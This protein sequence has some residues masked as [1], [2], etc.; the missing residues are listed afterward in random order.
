MGFH[1]PSALSKPV[2]LLLSLLLV[3]A[4]TR[5]DAARDAWLAGLKEIPGRHVVLRAPAD[6]AKDSEIRDL[7][8]RLDVAAERMARKVPVEIDE[9]LQVFLEEDYVRQGR[10]VGEI[11]EAVLDE[12]GAVHLVFHRQD[13]P[14]YRQTVA[15]ALVRRLR[16]DL[17]PWI[18]RGAAL[19]L[20]ADWYGKPY[21]DWLPLFAAA[22]V[23]PT[24][25]QLLSREVQPDSSDLLWV[26]AA[27]H[28][29]GSRPGETLTDR[30]ATLPSRDEIASRL[31]AVRP[32]AADPGPARRAPARPF[33]HGVSFAMSNGLEIGYHAPSAI[34]RLNRL[35]GLGADAVSLMPFAYQ[36][37]P[38]APELRYLRRSPSSE[39][40]VGML[41]A[42]RQAHQRGMT[43]LW[44]PQI[45]LSHGS[46]P[47]EIR[48]TSEDDWEVW[49]AS[50]RRFILHHAVLARW[51]EVE[52]FSVGVELGETLDRQREWHQ[53]IRGARLL[54][55]GTLTYAANWH[56]DAEHAPFWPRLDAIGVDAYY[57]LAG[58]AEA[59]GETLREGARA[60]RGRLA[61]LAREHDRPIL[62]TEV[63]F[64]ARRSAW[65]SPH[66]EGGEFHPEDQ[67]RAYEVL[68]GELGKPPWLAGVFVWKAFSG[69]RGRPD[70]RPDFRFLDRPAAEIVETY[71]ER[72]LKARSP[73]TA[74]RP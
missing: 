34:E 64:A 56:G 48:M 11:G 51:A 54:F 14:A 35:A 28:V 69:D 33:L 19:W 21:E 45:W 40:D 3:P 73:A 8:R 31:A 74:G 13:E 68:F 10:Y 15:L 41:H 44:K 43:V 29:V 67:R 1:S 42:A 23:L 59:D 37:A 25:E 60:V 22:G 27:A 71:F 65:A 30:L 36:P 12:A 63:G 52:W 46:W 72:P 47:G 38:D 6:R 57:P 70:D 16:D 62:L 2:L 58:S 50:Y 61:A 17:P 5:A 39:T 26:P 20:S 55:P 9:P 7:Q 18:E 24:A 32:S 4:C 66:E 53:L 49:W